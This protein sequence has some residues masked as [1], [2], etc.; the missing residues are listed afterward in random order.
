MF[1]VVESKGKSANL[2]KVGSK[3]RRTKVELEESKEEERLRQEGIDTKARQIE[4]LTQRLQQVQQEAE[5]NNAASR[6]LQG[7]IEG[8]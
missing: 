3:R 1:C 8:G 2:F 5:S 7:F 4:E 6:I